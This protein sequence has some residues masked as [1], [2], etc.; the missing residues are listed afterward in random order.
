VTDYLL[1]EAGVR[2][3]YG[4]Y[5]DALWRKDFAAFGDCFAEDAVWKIAGHTIQGRGEIIAMLEA[6]MAT[7]HKVAIFTG[8]HVVS[9]EGGEVTARTQVTEYSKLKD[10]T[11]IR[12]LAVYY[13][14]VVEQDGRW[15]FQWHHFDMS[16]YGPPDFSAPYY[17]C[18]DYGPPPG[19]PGPDAPTTVRS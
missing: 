1:A 13:D 9:V 5:A 12:T 16:Y 4:L 2:R 14:R 8:P 6:A 3:L 17:D 19:F 18:A 10:G 15:R 11:A 7:A